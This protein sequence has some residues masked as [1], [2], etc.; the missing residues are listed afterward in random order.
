MNIDKYNFILI[1]S[2]GRSGSTTLQRILNTIPETN[3]FGENNSA[4]LHLLRFYKSIKSKQ[5][6]NKKYDHFVKNELKPC[7][8][9]YFNEKDIKN[10]IKEMIISFLNYDKAT[11]IGF[12]EIRYSEKNDDL[13]LLHEFKEL[14]PN[15]KILIHI[16]NDTKKQSQSDWWGENSKESEKY[17]INTNKYLTN[18]YN[19]N[20]DFVYLSTFED[21]FN[22]DKLLKLFEFIGKKEHFN[23]KSIQKILENNLG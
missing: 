7:W 1:C 19:T 6:I 20:K 13:S 22:H 14:F 15:V 8:Y 18:F 3:I 11:T 12:K 16:R 9:N 2:I 10:K 5:I 4:I 17:I 21:M 23:K